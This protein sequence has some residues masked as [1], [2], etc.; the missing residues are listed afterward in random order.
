MEVILE[1]SQEEAEKLGFHKEKRISL[2]MLK[3]ALDKE[4]IKKA[5]DKSYQDAVKH[6][7]ADMSMEEI[8]NLISEA[9]EEYRKQHEKNNP[10]Y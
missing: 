9:K 6:G 5:L 4:K 2:A 7:Y 1:M 8:N 10:W 3:K